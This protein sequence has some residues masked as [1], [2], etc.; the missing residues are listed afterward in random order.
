ME[1]Q[2]P[3][4]L[5]PFVLENP[6]APEVKDPSESL[7]NEEYAA[8]LELYGEALISKKAKLSESLSNEEYAARLE[9]YGTVLRPLYAQRPRRDF[10]YL[11]FPEDTFGCRVGLEATLRRTTDVVEYEMPRDG[12][13]ALEMVIHS[14]NK[15][16]DGVVTDLNMPSM[17]GAEFAQRVRTQ[18]GLTR[19]HLPIY[20]R[21]TEPR[22]AALTL[23][24]FNSET[25][26]C[27]DD[28]PAGKIRLEHE[29]R[30]L[31]DSGAFS[32]PSLES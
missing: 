28:T 29:L 23:A 25:S 26:L 10:T 22:L 12:N 9:V 19:K 2:S 14:Q 17:G 18:L 30:G 7:S 21:S 24:L 15:P 4:P 31:I 3:T 11:L 27:K 8:R 5:S 20:F 16:F 32:P 6:L 13:E 1:A